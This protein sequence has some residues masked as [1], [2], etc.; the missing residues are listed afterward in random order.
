M[1]AAIQLVGISVTVW[2]TVAAAEVGRYFKEVNRTGRAVE[3]RRLRK[4]ELV[5]DA[6]AVWATASVAEVGRN[7]KEI[8]RTGRLPQ[9]ECLRMPTFATEVVVG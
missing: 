2:A 7:F 8:N 6:V 9:T 3:G 1:V 4:I 5:G